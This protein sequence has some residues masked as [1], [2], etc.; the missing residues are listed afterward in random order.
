MEY[1]PLLLIRRA[2]LEEYT[3]EVTQFRN[4]EELDRSTKLQTLDPLLR[5]GGLP[6]KRD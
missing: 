4:G 2:Q 1:A 5:V 6:A 3:K